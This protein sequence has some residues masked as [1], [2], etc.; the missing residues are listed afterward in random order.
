[1]AAQ[2]PRACLVCHFER[3]NRHTNRS[4]WKQ[5]WKPLSHPNTTG[6]R[7][8]DLSKFNTTSIFLSDRCVNDVAFKMWNF[9]WR[10]LCKG[11]LFIG[12]RRGRQPPVSQG[13]SSP[14]WGGYLSLVEKAEASI[15][16][17]GIT[18]FPIGWSVFGEMNQSERLC[19]LQK[20]LLFI[21]L[22][23]SLHQ[24]ISLYDQFLC[25]NMRH[26]PPR[27]LL[28]C[29]PLFALT[30]KKRSICDLL[31]PSVTTFLKYLIT[32]T[33]LAFLNPMLLTDLSP[34]YSSF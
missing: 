17:V 7:K 26:A 11:R 25:S 32:H 27:L 33:S 31:A 15:W 24:N 3:P 1:M 16:F 28:H 4:N 21:C 8:K 12:D 5:K 6:K 2:S 13:K 29:S 10:R 19:F 23:Q 14:I 34:R 9:E 22:S 18:T 20:I 30:L